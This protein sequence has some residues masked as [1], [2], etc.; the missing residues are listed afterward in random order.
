MYF[1]PLNEIKEREKDRER[2][3]ERER[4]R[5]GEERRKGDCDI[6]EGERED[7]ERS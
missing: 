3:R 4:E 5:K 7:R 1:G 2:E 6:R